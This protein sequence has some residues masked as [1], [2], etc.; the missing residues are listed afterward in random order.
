[1]PHFEDLKRILLGD[2]SKDFAFVSYGIEDGAKQ[3]AAVPKGNIQKI[4]KIAKSIL[5]V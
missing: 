3:F 5:A 2:K 1:L 4:G